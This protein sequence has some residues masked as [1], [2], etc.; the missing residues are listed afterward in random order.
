M[1][2]KVKKLNQDKP[3]LSVYINPLSIKELPVFKNLTTA[4]KLYCVQELSRELLNTQIPGS[5]PQ[6]LSDS[7]N[8]GW[9]L[10]NYI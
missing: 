10:E 1:F 2:K 6:I 9:S 7:V 8:L 3:V 5:Y 4:L